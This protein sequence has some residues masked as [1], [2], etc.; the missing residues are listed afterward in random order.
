MTENGNHDKKKSGGENS[1]I[2][3][4][5]PDYLKIGMKRKSSKPFKEE[6]PKSLA[7]IRD[8]NVDSSSSKG[9]SL[10]DQQIL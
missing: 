2:S 8:E 7:N 6:P 1:N 5:K 9:C 3:T 4:E 10:S